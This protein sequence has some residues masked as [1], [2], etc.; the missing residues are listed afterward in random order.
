MEKKKLVEDWKERVTDGGPL[1]SKAGPLLG[2]GE[3][4][5]PLLPTALLKEGNQLVSNGIP[6]RLGLLLPARWDAG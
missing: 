1:I 5:A 4:L 2:E 6:I 3:E